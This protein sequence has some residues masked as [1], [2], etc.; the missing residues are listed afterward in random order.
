MWRN[1]YGGLEPEEAKP[2]KELE[3]ENVRL[4]R[5]AA[6]L[7]LDKQMVQEVVQIKYGRPTRVA[8]LCVSVY[9]C[10]HSSRDDIGGLGDVAHCSES[11][12]EKRLRRAVPTKRLPHR[13]LSL[14]AWLRRT[15]SD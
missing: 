6:A 12:V 11:A 1:Q 8:R 10:D 4:K 9:R 7:A 3:A 2:L 13:C 15:V 14:G 5:L